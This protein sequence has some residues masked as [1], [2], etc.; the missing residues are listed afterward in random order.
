MFTFDVE[1]TRP[2]VTEID[3]T[4][5]KH[6]PHETIPEGIKY[7]TSQDMDRIVK[8]KAMGPISVMSHGSLPN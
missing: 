8:K 2:E 6:D 1:N 4:E 7:R 3:E 5:I